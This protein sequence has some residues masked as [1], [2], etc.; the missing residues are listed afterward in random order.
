MAKKASKK[1]ATAAKKEY[2]PRQLPK[3]ADVDVKDGNFVITI[4]IERRPSSTGKSEILAST[5]GNCVVPIEFEG[6]EGKV[7]MMG[8]NIYSY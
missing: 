2:K 3:G 6:E 4:P 7:I 5:G 8:L 1:T